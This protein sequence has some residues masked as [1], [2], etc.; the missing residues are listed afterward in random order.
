M[1]R[2]LMTLV[3]FTAL[4]T[5]AFAQDDHCDACTLQVG[6]AVVTTSNGFLGRLGG[7]P[8][9]VTAFE[10]LGLRSEVPALQ[11]GVLPATLTTR[12]TLFANANIRLSANV[13]VGIMNPSST[14]AVVTMTLRDTNGNL[15]ASD[16]LTIGSLQQTAKFISEFFANVPNAPPDFAGTL[17]VTSDSPVGIVA[18]AFNGGIFT[19]IPIS[20]LSPAVPFPQLTSVVGGSSGV[21][22]PQFVA[23][24]GWASEIVLL[25]NSNAPVTA[26]I[27]VFQP[28][29]AAMMATLNHVSA[30]S[31][32]NLVIAPGGVI[33]VAPLNANGDSDF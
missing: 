2:L 10:T 26:R 18:L 13:G 29:G 12:L 19:T 6:Y 17:T 16:I 22:L 33:V 14:A 23:N 9:G 5:A 8:S 27:D 4:S 28:S 25:N 21:L 31:F 3:C 15:T 1:R 30:S 7:G 24:A 11:A 32:Q 20:S